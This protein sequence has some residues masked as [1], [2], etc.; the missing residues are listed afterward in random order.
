MMSKWQPPSNLAQYIGGM[1]QVTR[2]E[3]L[4]LDDGK[5]RGMR[6]IQVDNGSG[7]AFTV[8]PDRG[9]D[10]GAASYCGMPIAYQTSVGMVNPAYAE[11]EGF[12]WLRSFGGGLLAGCG[13]TYAGAPEPTDALNLSGPSGLHGR[14]S[15]TPAEAVN[16]DASWDEDR[17]CLTVSG[18]IR[19]NS[20]FGHNI[21]MRRTVRCYMGSNVIEIDDDVTNESPR[22]SP[23]MMM[24][25][26]NVGYP[27]LSESAYLEGDVDKTEPRDEVAAHGLEAWGRCQKPEAGFVEQC[28]YHDIAADSDGF[29]RMSLCNPDCG[30]RFEVSFR[31]KELP[32][33]TEWKMMGEREYVV[34]IEPGN[35]FPDGRE[36][37]RE[38]GRLVT[39][40]SGESTYH[41]V[42]I[43]LSQL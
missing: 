2:L 30:V 11:A 25:H 6:V 10:L 27:L 21:V 39:L 36:K 23:L 13:L 20:F 4:V 31:K 41:R 22:E 16:T 37:S 19:E 42:R 38:R 35:C 5:G 28:Y 15:S 1:H 17:Y 29:A 18:I 9:M 7:L 8:L 12:G 3:R 14:L 33:L 40:S 34:G 43:A 32:C 24:Y 26:I